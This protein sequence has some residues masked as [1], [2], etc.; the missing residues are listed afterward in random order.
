MRVRTGDRP[1]VPATSML[2]VLALG[3][4]HGATVTL[5]A[6]GPGAEEALDALAALLSRDLD[7]DEPADG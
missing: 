7:A 4:G 6:E 5:Q 1:S 3:A 2:G